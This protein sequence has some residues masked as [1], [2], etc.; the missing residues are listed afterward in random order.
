MFSCTVAI[1][2]GCY[3]YADEHWRDTVVARLNDSIDLSR[4]DSATRVANLHVLL[5]R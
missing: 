3:I 4:M 1:A 2:L 5:Q